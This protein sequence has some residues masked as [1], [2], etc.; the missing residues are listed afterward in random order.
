[1]PELRKVAI[2]ID[3]ETLN[4]EASSSPLKDHPGVSRTLVLKQPCRDAAVALILNQVV[5]VPGAA[6]KSKRTH[7]R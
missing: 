4:L 5:R 3:S 1:M 2:A 7:A 6:S